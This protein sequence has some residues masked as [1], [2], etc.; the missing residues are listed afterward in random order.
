M[1]IALLNEFSQASKNEMILKEL[2]AAVEPMGHKVYNCAMV[3]PLIRG[4]YQKLTQEKIHV[5]LTCTLESW[6]LYY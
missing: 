4:M 5:L 6:Q 1:K 3:T 2:K